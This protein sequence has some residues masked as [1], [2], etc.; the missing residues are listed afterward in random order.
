MDG[1]CQTTDG[2]LE[3]YGYRG[4]DGKYGNNFHCLGRKNRWD[5]IAPPAV[6]DL[7]MIQN[8]DETNLIYLLY[9]VVRN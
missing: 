2:G 9:L 7:G 3:V 8:Q 6:G 5:G 4:I 1:L